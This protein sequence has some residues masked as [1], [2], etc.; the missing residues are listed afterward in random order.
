MKLFFYN[1]EEY[2][3]PHYLPVLVLE[4]DLLEW[5]ILL[6]VIHDMSLNVNEIQHF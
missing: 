3:F 1:L 5:E 4:I 2:H 6:L